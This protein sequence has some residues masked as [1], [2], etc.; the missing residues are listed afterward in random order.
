M[1]DAVG[2]RQRSPS[3]GRLLRRI[4]S[5]LFWAVVLLLGAFG[6]YFSFANYPW[7]AGGVLLLVLVAVA[8]SEQR[9][10]AK[11]KAREAARA[12]AR[13]EAPAPTARA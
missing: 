8:Y 10:R 7:L 1:E 6:V 9:R 4:G 11:L 3:P 13:A 12:R 2:R 5:V